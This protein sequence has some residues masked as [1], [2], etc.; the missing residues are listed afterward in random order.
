MYCIVCYKECY[1]VCYG[2][3]VVRVIIGGFSPPVIL[4]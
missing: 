3:G 2:I 4:Y 1:G